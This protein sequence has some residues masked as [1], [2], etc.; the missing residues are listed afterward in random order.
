MNSNS[1]VKR[2][3]EEMRKAT[4]WFPAAV[5]AIIDLPHKVTIVILFLLRLSDS[6]FLIYF[7]TLAPG[8][9]G[10]FAIS[11]ATSTQTNPHAAPVL[12]T[13]KDPLVC[14]SKLLELAKFWSCLRKCLTIIKQP[15]DK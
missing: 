12:P 4:S 7:Q 13:L 3:S 6:S 2:L 10:I 11:T 8:I 14:S 1:V 9:S 15:Q 5:I